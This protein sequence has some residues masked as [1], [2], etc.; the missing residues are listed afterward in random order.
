MKNLSFISGYKKLSPPI[1]LWRLTK[2]C[3][4]KCMHCSHHLNRDKID[5]EKL[6]YAAHKIAQSKTMVVDISGGEPFLVPNIKELIL[7]LKNARK[8][9]MLNTNGFHLREYADFLIENEID[10]LAISFDSHIAELHDK[11]RGRK[12]SFEKALEGVKYII[13]NR[14]DK[15]KPYILIRGVVMKDNYHEV[16]E[17]V[18]FFRQWADEVKFQPIHDYEGFDEASNKDVLFDIKKKELEED[19]AFHMATLIKKDKKFNNGYYKTFQKFVFHKEELESEALNYC[20]PVWF[21][22][23]IIFE[24]GHCM[25]CTQEIGNIYSDK[26]LDEIWVSSKRLDYLTSLVHFGKCKMPCL[27]TCTGAGQKWQGKMIREALLMRSVNK[28]YEDEFKSTP[29][30]LGL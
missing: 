21:I 13:E 19:F 6:I 7:I 18:D 11:I 17:Y 8:K 30:Y 15:K 14:G 3:N 27:L 26:P 28:E 23:L 20:L 9:I 4:L 2:R 1:T 10:Y 5:T 29:N 25:T 24:H 12:G 16:S 22:L